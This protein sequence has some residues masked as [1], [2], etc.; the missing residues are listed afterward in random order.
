MNQ[1]PISGELRHQLMKVRVHQYL[2]IL[3]KCF[4][5][6]TKLCNTICLVS[7]GDILTD[8]LLL[9]SLLHPESLLPLLRYKHLLVKQE[10][11]HFVP[12]GVVAVAE[13]ITLSLVIP[14]L[15]NAQHP[16]LNSFLAVCQFH[17][18]GFHRIS[19]SD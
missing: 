1:N 14:L 9:G 11:Q 6:G 5:L 8:I 19:L 7:F 15:G 2:V 4:D 16:S 10:I 13:L 18:C 12:V 17:G 3:P